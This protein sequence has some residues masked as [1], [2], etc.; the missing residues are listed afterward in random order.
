VGQVQDDEHL[1]LIAVIGMGRPHISRIRRKVERERRTGT[2]YATAV[3]SA[4]V[5]TM[6]K[7]LVRN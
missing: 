1:F 5:S 6:V 7:A 2:A 4:I 3:I